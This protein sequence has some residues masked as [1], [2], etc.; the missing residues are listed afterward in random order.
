MFLIAVLAALALGLARQGK[1]HSLGRLTLRRLWLPLLAYLIQFGLDYFAGMGGREP[2][3]GYVHLATYFLLSYWIYLNLQLP[4]MGLLAVGT[5]LNFAVIA[6][7]Q[8]FMPVDPEPLSQ[9]AY[10]T[11]ARGLNGTHILLTPETRMPWLADIIYLPRPRRELDSLGDL[12]LAAGGFWLIFKGMAK[13]E[14]ISSE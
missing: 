7:N 1:V 10:L 11:F 4:G 14:Q 8:G 13:K 3:M 2:W 6:L 5:L 12:V 9:T